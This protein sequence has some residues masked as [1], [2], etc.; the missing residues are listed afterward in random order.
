MPSAIFVCLECG[1]QIEAAWSGSSPP[2]EREEFQCEDCHAVTE[3]QRRFTPVSVGQVN[4]AGG[5]PARMGF[6]AK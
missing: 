2:L 3:F 6:M 4:G 5:S 1:S